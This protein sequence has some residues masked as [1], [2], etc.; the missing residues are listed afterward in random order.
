MQH[1]FR[2]GGRTKPFRFVETVNRQRSLVLP[3][4]AN[5]NQM[6]KLKKLVS[7]TA[8]VAA[9]GCFLTGSVIL[10]DSGGSGSAS[11]GTN[12][13]TGTCNGSLICVHVQKTVGGA[14]YDYWNCCTQQEINDGTC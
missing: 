1:R 14:N 13:Q 9:A 8:L 4:K 10:A 11:C 12:G 2:F 7:K 3:A 6:N 5:K